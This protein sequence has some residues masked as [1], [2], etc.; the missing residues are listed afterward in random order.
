MLDSGTATQQSNPTPENFPGLKP[1]SLRPIGAYALYGLALW[2]DQ[3]VA[4]DT[5]RGYLLQMNPPNDNAIVLNPC[6]TDQ[7]IDAVGFSIWED[8]IWFTKDNSVYFCTF[9]QFEPQL[10]I[11]LPYDVDGVGVWESTIYVT[12]QKLGY[13]V[14][15]ERN[16]KR[17]I[18]Q[19]PLPG[20]GVTNLTIRGE[21]LWLCDRTE[22]TVYCLDRATGELQFNLLTPFE[23]PTA[24]AFLNASDTDHPTLYVSY[25]GEEAYIRDN[26]N[27]DPNLELT[28]RDRTFIHPL[29]FRYYPDERYTLSNGYLI[30]M[31]YVEELLPLDE[32]ELQDLE[33]RIA[34]PT[35]THR[36][37]IRSVEP[38]GL[39]FTEDIQDGQRVAV[40]KFASLKPQE[41]CIFGWKA[42]L[43]VRGI[44]YHFNFEDVEQS[45]VLTPEFRDRYLVDDDELAM[46]TPAIQQAAREAIGTETNLLR[47][48]L[49]IRNYVYDRLSY[50]IKPH[51]DSPDVVLERGTGSCGEYVGVLLA[52]ARL[53]G[54]ACRTVGRYKC[55]TFA[56]RQNVPLEPDY[57]HV[58]IEFYIPGYGWLPMESNP[59]DIVERGPYP[60][61]FFMGLPW[62]HAEIGKG[63][64]FESLRS[65]G[66][67]VGDVVDVS[68][69][70]LALNHIRFMILEE[71]PPL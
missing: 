28:Y 18:T 48:M 14:I 3:F 15:Y 40:F 27:A 36:Q 55:P 46:D 37:K 30:E 24:I 45:P 2:H 23:N 59:D 22:E 5:V 61:R 19:F 35:E 32:V 51:I 29:H 10:F 68:I 9:D 17:K 53:N 67:P 8:T 6:N 20:V 11:T 26:P 12:S 13:I 50:G 58:W 52:L 63:I 54:I 56:D 1:R 66:V 4:L 39:P 60:T 62:Y 70:D 38:V 16:T 47:K 43:E 49:K 33:W 44:K 34:L 21:E 57:N 71:L 41:R 31:S 7:F 65:Q 25:A 69:G 42:I 64:T